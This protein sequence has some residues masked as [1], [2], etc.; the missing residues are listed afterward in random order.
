MDAVLQQLP[1]LIGVIIGAGGSFVVTTTTQRAGF[2]RELA[3]RWD[4]RRMNAYAEYARA[5]KMSITLTMRVASSFGADPYPH[6]LTAEDGAAALGAATEAREPAWESLLL[7]GTPEVIEVAQRWNQAVWNMEQFIQAKG[8]NPERWR[9]L[10][11]A[12]D[13]LRGEFY[14]AARRDLGVPHAARR[15]SASSGADSG[16]AQA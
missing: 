13:S 2:R 1:A 6:P 3:A 16:T 12:S 11:Q 14:A 7:I 8:Q 5:Q 9:E 4:E 15:A 10:W